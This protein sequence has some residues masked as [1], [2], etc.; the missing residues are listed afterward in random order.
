[1]LSHSFRRAA[2][3][4]AGR[5]QAFHQRIRDVA[6]LLACQKRRLAQPDEFGAFLGRH[7]LLEVRP[8]VAEH[9]G[10][11]PL[12]E[13]D[14]EVLRDPPAHR[15]PDEMR[16][17]RPETVEHPEHILREVPEIERAFIIV[18]AAIAARIPGDGVEAAAERLDLPRPVLPVAA[19][20]VQEEHQRARPRPVDARAGASPR[21]RPSRCPSSTPSTTA[22][23]DRTG[24]RHPGPRSQPCAYTC[25]RL[26]RAAHP[27]ALAG[28]GGSWKTPCIV[29]WKCHVLYAATEALRFRFCISF[30][31][32]RSVPLHAV[33]AAAG[34]S[35]P[36]SGGTLF[37]RV[38]CLRARACPAR[39]LRRRGSRT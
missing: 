34:L 9:Q 28:Q 36:S 11:D 10:S 31:S 4:C 26:L 18:R 17:L 14:M 2:C 25:P 7:G 19:D 30:P 32:S 27:P 21:R 22:F 3:V 23:P 6:R 13:A 5:D 24:R 12:R 33:R 1:M 15:E 38:S 20:P 16:P 37:A 39:V 8:R 35:C 29:S